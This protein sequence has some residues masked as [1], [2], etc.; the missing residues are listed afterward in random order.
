MFKI[1][2]YKI[3]M[4][5]KDYGILLPITIETEDSEVIQQN[6]SFRF[7]IFQNT[8]KN[9]ILS[10]IYSVDSNNSFNFELTEEESEQL[11]VGTYKY[12]L[13]WL[14]NGEFLN[15]II[16]NESYVVM[17]KAGPGNES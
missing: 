6:D 11:P 15:N 14:R 10:K 9:L 2:N 16:R 3:S 1:S 4:V 12:D 13:D 8:N 17:E 5:E 7:N